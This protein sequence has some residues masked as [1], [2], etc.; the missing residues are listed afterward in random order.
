[1]SRIPKE[2]R[3]YVDQRYA[4]RPKGF[5]KADQRLINTPWG[6]FERNRVA[7]VAGW[8]AAGSPRYGRLPISVWVT[9]LSYECRDL[10]FVPLWYA[11]VLGGAIAGLCVGVSAR[12]KIIST[13]QE[14]GVEVIVR[15]EEV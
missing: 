14:E 9:V 7:A 13:I 6:R 5:R 4:P 12:G 2:L 1:M 15:R 11:G 8:E 3:I 10:L